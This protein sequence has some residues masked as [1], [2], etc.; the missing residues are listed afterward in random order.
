M[1]SI[2]PKDIIKNGVYKGLAIARRRV[3][4]SAGELLLRCNCGSM[5]FDIHVRPVGVVARVTSLVCRNCLRI[6]KIDDQAHLEGHRVKDDNLKEARHF[7]NKEVI[8][9][10]P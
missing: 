10:R 7:L 6:R 2:L 4:P 8:G 1:T 3:T 5:E 9:G